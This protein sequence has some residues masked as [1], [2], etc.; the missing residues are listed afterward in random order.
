MSHNWR[1]SRGLPAWVPAVA[2]L[3]AVCTSPF[4]VS[5]AKPASP[6]AAEDLPVGPLQS[7]AT[8]ACL[9]CHEAR[10]IVQQRLNKAG[11]TKEV[12]KMIKWGAVVDAKDR[13]MLIDYLA[14]FGPDQPPYEPP[15]TSQTKITQSQT[16]HG[17][18]AAER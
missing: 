2:V 13:D 9:E 7:K 15:R 17:K 6:K 3:A 18:A 8:R 14:D 12:D 16:T 4:W 5:S 11:W 1:F 10:I